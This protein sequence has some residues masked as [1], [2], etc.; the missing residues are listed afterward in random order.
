MR[1]LLKDARVLRILLLFGMPLV[2]TMILLIST[3]TLRIPGFSLSSFAHAMT[4]QATCASTQGTQ[5]ALCNQQNPLEQGCVQDAQTAEKVSVFDLQNTLIGEVDLR[6][7]QAC[8]AYWVRT[9]AYANALQVQA[10]DAIISFKNGKV[11]DRQN[12][13]T[14][15]GQRFLVFTDIIQLTM[16]P[17]IEGVFHLRGQPSPL[18]ISL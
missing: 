1:T 16:V 2:T 12:S 14:Q 5:Q 8:Q 6:H 18:T 9:I 11:Q 13:N 7:S 4:R 15:P 17:T 10:I 3:I